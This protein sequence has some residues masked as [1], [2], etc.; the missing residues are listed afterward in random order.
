[1]KPTSAPERKPP[2]EPAVSPE[3]PW[4]ATEEELEAL[5]RLGSEGLWSAGGHELKLT[6]LDKVLF[7]PPV[8]PDGSETSEPPV[9]KRELI[10]YFARIAPA[11]L[12]ETGHR[13]RPQ[14]FPSDVS[15][16]PARA[17]P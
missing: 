1:M 2:T 3:H 10:E 14:S 6:N 15:R 8:G 12:L 7:P 13:S 5:H 9:T 4:T 16:S 17:R 11:I